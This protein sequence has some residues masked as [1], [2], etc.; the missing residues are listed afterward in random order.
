MA[1]KK[2]GIV[3]LTPKFRVSY[4]KVFKP[5]WNK[6]SEQNEYSLVALF[7]KG[8]NCDELRAAALKVATE[9]WG[10]NPKRWPKNLKT[11]FKDQGEREKE[12]EDGTTTI[13][14]GYVKGNVMIQMKSKNKPEIIGPKKIDGEFPAITDESEFY[15]GCW[16]RANVYIQAFEIEGGVNRG[17]SISLNHLQKVKDDD[18]FSGRPKAEAV[19]AAI[20]DDE[21]EE[22]SGGDDDE[23]PF[24]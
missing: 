8:E 9:K 1:E 16:A 12:N 13:P 10:P 14:D 3:L 19:F 4:P 5:E 17:V 15:A 7:P 21:T 11:P 22:T 24:G 20:E 6:L 2:K 18:P 23:N